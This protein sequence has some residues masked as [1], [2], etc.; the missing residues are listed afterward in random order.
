LIDF[1]KKEQ[2]PEETNALI[3]AILIEINLSGFAVV[4]PAAAK[5]IAEVAG[6][7][8]RA[9]LLQVGIAEDTDIDLFNVVNDFAVDFADARGAELVGM[10][11]NQWDELVPNPDA[12]WAITDGTRELL[13]GQVRQAI[14]EGWSTKQLSNAVQ[15]SYGFSDARA[16]M[17]GRTEIA[18][19]QAAGTMEGWKASGVCT[20]KFW[21]LGS[22]HDIEDDCDSNVDDGTIPLDE[23]FSSGDEYEPVHPNCTCSTGVETED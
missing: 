20:G 6:S 8:G 10:K 11:Y 4:A 5:L 21:V 14:E 3:D 9:A 18:R 23:E 12:E 2:T 22:E 1:S 15:E 16:E 19:A 7:S 17:I 13:R